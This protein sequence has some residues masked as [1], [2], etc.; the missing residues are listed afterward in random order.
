M[1]FKITNPLTVEQEPQLTKNL[2]PFIE[3][4]EG[5][6]LIGQPSK[7]TIKGY[8]FN[9]ESEIICNAGILSNIQISP[10]AIYFDCLSS[11]PG[12][13]PVEVKNN[14]LSSNDWN[15]PSAPILIARNLLN[16]TDGWLDFRSVNSEN[17]GSII[18]HINQ[19]LATKNFTNSGYSLDAT[20]GLIFNGSG[21][22][23]S[24]NNY[25]QFNSL[26]FPLS[27]SKIEMILIIDT[28]SLNNRLR[29]SIGN[30]VTNNYVNYGID[31]PFNG[32]LGYVYRFGESTSACQAQLTINNSLPNNNNLI[33]K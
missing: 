24:T 32:Y 20:R 10:N 6:A 23:N 13:Y 4:I 18:S 21:T 9:P 11:F 28:F 19:N 14:S 5:T 12:S 27:E 16:I 33:M 15:R 1:P 8:N 31:S 22:V 3:E 26:E 29:I 25:I 30:P 7:I 2:T 17:L